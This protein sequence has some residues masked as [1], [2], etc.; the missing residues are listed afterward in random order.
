MNIFDNNRSD[1]VRLIN[2]CKER[3][4]LEEKKT[5]RIN[6][7]TLILVPAD[8]RNAEYAALYRQR[9]NR[10]IPNGMPVTRVESLNDDR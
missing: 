10:E 1:A 7:H 5:L 3:D 2:E 4:R 8:K 6:D 9:L